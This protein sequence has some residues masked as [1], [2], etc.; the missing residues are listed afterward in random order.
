[1]WVEWLLQ[2]VSNFV[3]FCNSFGNSK[4]FFL[5]GLEWLLVCSMKCLNSSPQKIVL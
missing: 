5:V 3:G 1:M 4:F 2:N